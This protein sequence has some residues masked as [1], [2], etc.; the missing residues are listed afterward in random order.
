MDS[1]LDLN[2]KDIGTEGLEEFRIQRG[3][4]NDFDLMLSQCFEATSVIDT[5]WNILVLIMTEQKRFTCY[6]WSKTI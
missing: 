3:F 4:F 2:L 5:K 6:R 1:V